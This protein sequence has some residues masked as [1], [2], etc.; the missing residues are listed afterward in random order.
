MVTVRLLYVHPPEEVHGAFRDVASAQED[1]L[2]TINRARTF[3]VEKVQPG[4]GEAAAMVQEAL[5][6]RDEQILK[7]R[8]EAAGFGLQAD[9]YRAAP[10]LT[11]FRLQLEAIEEVLPGTARSLGRA[12]ATSSSSIYGSWSRSAGKRGDGGAQAAPR[13][14]ANLCPD[15]IGRTLAIWGGDIALIACFAASWTPAMIRR[16]NADPF[17]F[18]RPLERGARAHG[19]RATRHAPLDRHGRGHLPDGVAFNRLTTGTPGSWCSTRPWWSANPL[20]TLRPEIALVRSIDD[21]S[22]GLVDAPL[23]LVRSIPAQV[24]RPPHSAAMP[25]PNTEFCAIGR[26]MLR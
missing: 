13:G 11:T 12:S 7:S 9:A 25:P 2:R 4:R 5:A 1:K 20:G 15:R 21:Q 8:D 26:A 23:Y 14:R 3:A 10:D 16:W 22:D 19:Q 24:G 6:F 17:G 18:L